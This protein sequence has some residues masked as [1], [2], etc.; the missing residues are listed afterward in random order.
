MG[1]SRSSTCVLAYLIL[2][3]QMSADEA[4]NTVS[5]RQIVNCLS[6]P[7]TLEVDFIWIFCCGRT[8]LYAK[9]LLFSILYAL[10]VWFDLGGKRWWFAVGQIQFLSKRSSWA[11][12]R[13]LYMFPP[14][15]LGKTIW[16]PPITLFFLQFEYEWNTCQ[17]FFKKAMYTL[18]GFIWRPPIGQ[19]YYMGT[20]LVIFFISWRIK[21]S[22]HFKTL[23]RSG[24]EARLA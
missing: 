21:I 19:W 15:T 4:L 7:L 9:I 18:F 5:I 20:F 24:Q 10:M 13:L 22:Q 16:M 17:I 2:R 6:H 23:I 1:M 11:F 3:H 14:R 12:Q 8:F